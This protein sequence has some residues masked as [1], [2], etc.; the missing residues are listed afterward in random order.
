MQPQFP[1][2]LFI[3]RLVVI[4]PGIIITPQGKSLALLA[5][6]PVEDVANL[7]IV[8]NNGIANCI[9]G[10]LSGENKIPHV[11]IWLHAVPGYDHVTHRAT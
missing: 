1:L 8:I 10:L 9:L 11:K 3:S 5:D 6:N 2:D 7:R 4:L